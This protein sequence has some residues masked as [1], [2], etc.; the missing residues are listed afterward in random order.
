[1]GAAGLLLR[2]DARAAQQH[3]LYTKCCKCLTPPPQPIPARSTQVC[4]AGLP[5]RAAA[6]ARQWARGARGLGRARRPLFAGLAAA[7]RLPSCG[8]LACMPPGLSSSVCIPR[9]RLC[10]L[11]LCPPHFRRCAPTRVW[12]LLTTSSLTCPLCHHCACA[13]QVRSYLHVADV[14]EAFDIIMHKA[15]GRVC[16]FRRRAGTPAAC[17]CLP[18]PAP[19]SQPPAFVAAGARLRLCA[20][21]AAHPLLSE[22]QAVACSTRRALQGELGEI[23]NI[24][25]QRERTVL[26]VRRRAAAGRP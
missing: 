14:A 23:Y 22:R 15:S 8:A 6:G 9:A 16:C 24:G 12:P 2:G 7:W 13:A 17:P 20:H 3:C 19:A 25:S 18:L 10:S 26:E 21:A 1:M 5:R 11:P 4:A